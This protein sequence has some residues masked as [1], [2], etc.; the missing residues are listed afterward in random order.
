MSESK[1]ESMFIDNILDGK[2][3]G[4]V[5]REREEEER[6]LEKRMAK[7]KPTDL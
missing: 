6:L 4:D 1:T 7:N 5:L 3:L 2:K